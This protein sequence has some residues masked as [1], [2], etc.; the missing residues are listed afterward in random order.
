[1]KLTFYL[2][3]FSSAGNRNAYE[4]YCGEGIPL[5]KTVLIF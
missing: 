1:V 4:L 3:D 2:V 5:E